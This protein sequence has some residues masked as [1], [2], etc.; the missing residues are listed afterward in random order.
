MVHQ[1]VAAFSSRNDRARSPYVTS[2]DSGHEHS[3]EHWMEVRGLVEEA[4]G[5]AEAPARTADHG[6]IVAA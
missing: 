4:S 1:R 5:D 3:L 6:I 2:Y